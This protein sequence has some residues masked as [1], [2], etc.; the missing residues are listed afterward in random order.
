VL[1]ENF[2][3]LHHGQHTSVADA[4]ATGQ[5][6]ELRSLTATFTIPRR[7]PGDIRLNPALGGGALLDVGSYPLRIAQHVLGP[8]LEVVGSALRFDPVHGVDVGGSALL[9]RPD[10]VTARL[11]FGLDDAYVCEYELFGSEG[12]MTLRRAFTPPADYSPVLRIERASGVE[13]QVLPAEDR[14]LNTL[15]AFAAAVRDDATDAGRGDAI[16]RQ[17]ELLDSVRTHAVVVR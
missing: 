2:M 13:E 11:S 4:L 14:C 1:M 8:D 6:G 5:I 12:R 9:Y 15:R 7:D 3:F 16:V 17:A 10:G